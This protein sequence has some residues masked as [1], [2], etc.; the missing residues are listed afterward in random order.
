MDEILERITNIFYFADSNHVLMYAAG[1]YLVA[2]AVVLVVYYILARHSN[3]KRV[4]GGVIC[5]GV[6]LN[7]RLDGR[8]S[9]DP[10]TMSYG[11][12]WIGMQDAPNAERYRMNPKRSFMEKASAPDYPVS[13]FLARFYDALRASGMASDPGVIL[14]EELLQNESYCAK[15]GRLCQRGGKRGLTIL[16][17]RSHRKDRTNPNRVRIEVRIPE[18]VGKRFEQSTG[19]CIA[20]RLCITMEKV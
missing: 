10:L 17:N 12:Y 4:I 6:T 7:D 1:L 9:G 11:K 18:Q 19:G 14:L 2:L 3:Q 13:Y 16:G 20:E 8:K 15:M 5:V